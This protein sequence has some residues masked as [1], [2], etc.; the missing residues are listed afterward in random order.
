MCYL[1]L[2]DFK[3]DLPAKPNLEQKKKRLLKVKSLLS[4]ATNMK[5]VE[6]NMNFFDRTLCKDKVEKLVAEQY[7]LSREF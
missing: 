2:Q 7:S 4:L 1:C 6:D 3:F 5:S